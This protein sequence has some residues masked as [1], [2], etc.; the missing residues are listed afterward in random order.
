MTDAD[1]PRLADF[2]DLKDAALRADEF[3]GRRGVFIAEGEFVLRVLART[4]YPIKTVLGTAQRLAAVADVIAGLAPQVAVL[5]ADE[6][7][8]RRLVGFDFHRGVLASGVRVPSAGMAALARTSR[9]VVVVE[10]LTSPEN[11]G[12]IFR[13]TAALGGERVGVVLCPRTC[14]PL[15]RR[16]VRVSMGNVLRV[17][18]ERTEAWPGALDALRDAGFRVVALTPDA[19][20]T[21]IRE[22]PAAGRAAE[23]GSGG[24]SG[25]VLRYAL[26][27]GSEG[28]GLSEAAMAR[29]DVR[30]RIPQA[31]G[32]DSLNVGVAC[33][34]ALHRL[35]EVE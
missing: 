3:A 20:A 2:A 35:V 19:G 11:L 31:P 17:P 27:L 9:G 22:L 32:V 30:A 24:A 23:G 29:A 26:L 34:V 12:S 33:A 10:G 13:S 5:C 7:L 1:D 4:A 14:D 28:F 18:F 6:A 21:D 15:Y 8:I 25:G 16:V